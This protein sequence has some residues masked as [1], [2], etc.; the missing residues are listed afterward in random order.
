MCALFSSNMFSALILVYLFSLSF[1]FQYTLN[2]C[3]DCCLCRRRRSD[4]HG[5]YELKRQCHSPP[6]PYVRPAVK[7]T[8]SPLA[9]RL[10]VARAVDTH[11]SDLRG[12]V[13]SPLLSP[14][15]TGC[16]PSLG[17]ASEDND[18]ISLRSA[19]KDKVYIL[20]AL[21]FTVDNLT[22]W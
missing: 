14:R 2:H 21:C 17:E 4:D 16:L 20:T 18:L 5:Q 6:G 1:G 15:P 19:A 3:R 9:N 8:G 13:S 7:S 12:R 10:D 22:C 11:P